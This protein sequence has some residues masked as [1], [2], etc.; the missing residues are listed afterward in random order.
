MRNASPTRVVMK[1]NWSTRVEDRSSLSSTVLLQS[2]ASMML[3]KTSFAKIRLF[4]ISLRRMRLWTSATLSKS[5]ARP[6][7]TSLFP[8]GWTLSWRATPATEEWPRSSIE[9]TTK[10][11]RSSKWVMPNSDTFTMSTHPLSSLLTVKKTPFLEEMSST[12]RLNLMICSSPS[13]FHSRRITLIF[14]A[15]ETLSLLSMILSSL[16]RICRFWWKIMINYL[17]LPKILKRL[18]STVIN[19]ECVMTISS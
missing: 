12:Y 2:I 11:M 4:S 1:S 15:K 5:D 16:A 3:D 7:E 17:P 10:S 19:Q 18:N 6:R 9:C 13:I 8:L 14:R